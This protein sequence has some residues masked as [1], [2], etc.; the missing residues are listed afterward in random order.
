M[1]FL[2]ESAAVLRKKGLINTQTT[3]CYMSIWLAVV[4]VVVCVCTSLCGNTVILSFTALNYTWVHD[5][6]IP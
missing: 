2:A 5:R 1:L 6:A 3:Y 4:H